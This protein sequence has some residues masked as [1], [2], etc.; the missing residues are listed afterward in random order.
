[1]IGTGKTHS[2]SRAR[3]EEAEHVIL[4]I[5]LP[6]LLSDNMGEDPKTTAVESKPINATAWNRLLTIAAYKILR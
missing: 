5:L 2:L 3:S 6:P 4:V 1:M